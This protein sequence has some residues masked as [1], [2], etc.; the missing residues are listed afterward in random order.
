M[1][2]ITLLNTF[3]RHFLHPFIKKI[4]INNRDNKAWYVRKSASPYFILLIIMINEYTTRR[5]VEA[6]LILF[7]VFISN[8][9]TYY[10]MTGYYQYNIPK[11]IFFYN[12]I[13]QNKKNLQKTTESSK[14]CMYIT[15]LFLFVTPSIGLKKWNA[16]F[17]IITQLLIYLEITLNK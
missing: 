11:N 2:K 15:K 10:M 13:L 8:N 17:Q 5:K 9:M 7:F 3:K 14:T 12:S 1:T 4:T 6:I 16:Y